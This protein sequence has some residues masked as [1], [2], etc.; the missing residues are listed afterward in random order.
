MA[1]AAQLILCTGEETNK[2]LRIAFSRDPGTRGLRLR[3]ARLRAL[4]RDTGSHVWRGY[5][6]RRS[7]RRNLHPRLRARRRGAVRCRLHS[8]SVSVS[9]AAGLFTLRRSAAGTPGAR[10]GGQNSFQSLGCPTLSASPSS[11]ASTRSDTFLIRCPCSFR[12][13]SSCTELSLAASETRIFCRRRSSG[14][15]G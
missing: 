5:D 4:P 8:H 6:A 2:Y 11:T 12:N 15:S 1:L 14:G 13:V 10:Q 7:R 3:Q 9:F